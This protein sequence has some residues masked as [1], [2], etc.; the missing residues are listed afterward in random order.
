MLAFNGGSNMTVGTPPL[1]R[2][3]L[4]GNY[5]NIDNPS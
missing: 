2:S 5:F 1:I 3:P 4:I